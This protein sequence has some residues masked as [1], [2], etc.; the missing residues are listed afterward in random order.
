MVATVDH[1]E[2]IEP[3]TA[4]VW[5]SA[6]AFEDLDIT[7]TQSPDDVLADWKSLEEHATDFSSCSAWSLAWFEA[8]KTNRNCSPY[9]ILGKS[10]AGRPE[11]VFA[12]MK[13]KIGP[14]TILVRPG[15]KHSAYYA[16]IISPQL[17]KRIV[18]SG[19][20]AFW[21]RIIASV[22]GV[23]A[24]WIE[25]LTQTQLVNFDL[26][27]S[28]RS[29]N[30]CQRMPIDEDWGGQFN[31]LFNPKAQSDVRRCHKRLS[32]QGE[33]AFSV[34][35]DAGTQRAYLAEI[36]DQK[37][38]TITKMGIDS[39]FAPPEIVRFYGTIAAHCAGEPNTRLI[40][41]KLSLDGKI[42]SAN[43]G[44]CFRDTF[45]GMVISTTPD[46]IRK[47]SPSRLLLIELNQHLSES[48][49]SCHDFGTGSSEFK[50]FWCDETV[51]RFHVFI[52]IGLRGAIATMIMKLIK[53]GKMFLKTHS[54]SPLIARVI[55]IARRLARY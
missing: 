32:E 35:A 16:G 40:V 36:L 34:A 18:N 21:D 42:L 23:D 53:S 45:H 33:V 2:A 28:F 17:A 43:F 14:F 4:Q 44:I 19:S 39:P 13:R 26:Q 20:R 46:P 51:E 24:I 31:L 15:M 3:Q 38:L 5:E 7:I 52:P 22:Q 27:P 55:K 25:G 1:F 41:G 8:H 10:A 48:G 30:P 47:Y 49:V 12:F 50:D 54:D 11:F 6:G 37:N 9:I 29:S